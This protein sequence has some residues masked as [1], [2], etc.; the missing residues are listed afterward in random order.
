[1]RVIRKTAEPESLTIWKKK[2]PQGRYED[3]DSSVRRDIRQK[4]LSEQYYLCAYC[5]QRI[6]DI[7]DCHNEHLEAQSLN[8]KRTLDFQNIVAS[9][10]TP[11]QCGRSHQSQP[12]PLTPVMD[13]CE[14]ELLFRISGRVEGLTERACTT[15][16][17]LNLGDRNKPNLA[18]IE[19]RRQLV[20][21]LLWEHGIN[22]DQGLM[23]DLEDDEFL[24]D[25]YEEILHDLQ[26]PQGEK[27]DAFAPVAVSIIRNWLSSR[28]P[29]K[30]SK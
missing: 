27:L 5:C 19:K 25:F 22:P 29:A 2:H 3:L 12:L 4:S 1:M 28:N 13:E 9:C 16:Q 17:V 18:L 14:T 6:T 15:I 7:G 26:K 24:Y 10:D 11:G 20:N 30:K 23:Q 8:P 21:A